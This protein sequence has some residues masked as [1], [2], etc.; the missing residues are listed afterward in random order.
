MAWHIYDFGTYLGFDTE[1]IRLNRVMAVQRL[2]NIL[3]D[4]GIVGGDRV[5]EN[6]IEEAGFR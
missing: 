5:S 2:D 1:E 3:T 4:A 6:M